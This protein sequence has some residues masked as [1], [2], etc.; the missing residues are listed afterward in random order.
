MVQLPVIKNAKWDKKQNE[1][2]ILKYFFH[3]YF[4]LKGKPTNLRHSK[5]TTTSVY[6]NFNNANED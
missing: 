5:S 6:Y 2:K 1:I 4:K 3:F